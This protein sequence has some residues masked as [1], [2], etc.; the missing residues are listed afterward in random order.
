MKE[1]L[2]NLF[3]HSVIVEDKV[4]KSLFALSLNKICRFSG[5]IDFVIFSSGSILNRA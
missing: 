1:G 4:L 2:V 3:L 5:G